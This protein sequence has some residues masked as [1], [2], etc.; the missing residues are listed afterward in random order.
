MENFDKIAL[1]NEKKFDFMANRKNLFLTLLS[2]GEFG[3]QAVIFCANACSGDFFN[4]LSANQILSCA[5]N[6]VQIIQC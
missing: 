5:S 3:S 6:A 2:D 4:I 1:K